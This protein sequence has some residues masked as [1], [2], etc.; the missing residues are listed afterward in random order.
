MLIFV[1]DDEQPLLNSARRII[2]EA[3]PD[4]EIVTFNDALD[5]INHIIE[6]GQKPD[7]VFS[8]IE[9]PGINGLE[10]AVRLKSLSPDTRVVFVTG[11]LNYAVDAFKV[12]AQGYIMKPLSV[13]DVVDEL[14]AIPPKEVI[15]QDKLFVRCFGHFEVFWHGE[16]LIFQRKKTKEMLAFL[17]DRE[18]A[19]CTAY[20]IAG[21]LWEERMDAKKAGQ[22]VRNLISDLKNTLTQIGMEDVLIRDRQQVAIRRDLIDCDYYNMLAGD[23]AW[24]NA[25]KGEYM[26]DYSWAE[27]TAGKLYF[28]KDEK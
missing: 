21:S 13:E 3:A 10:L 6:K 4:A 8:D 18:G 25:Y 19:T 2:G 20:E 15:K 9:M 5:A 27:L 12:H 24:V 22:N 7:V 11:Y 1:I 14:A 23:M 16:P 28:R 17:V 26:M